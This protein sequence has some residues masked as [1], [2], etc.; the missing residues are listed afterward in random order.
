[1]RYVSPAL[2]LM[3]ALMLQAP[4]AYATPITFEGNLS[5]ANEVPAT[6]LAWDGHRNGG[7]GSGAPHDARRRD[8]QRLDRDYDS[9]A[10]PLLPAFSL[11]RHDNV[12]V[13]TTTPAFPGFPL[14]VTVGDLLL[15]DF[16]LTLAS[17]Y[18]PAFR[19]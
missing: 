12:M 4:A 18:N 5:G 2:L 7:A 17:S 13:A 1:M 19:H 3:A 11:D 15:H 8:V 16:D 9:L 10:H 6:G 14:G